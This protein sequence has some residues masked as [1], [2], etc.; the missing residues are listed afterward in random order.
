MAARCL[1]EFAKS[2]VSPEMNIPLQSTSV[3]DS[4]TGIFVLQRQYIL[5]LFTVSNL[6][7]GIALFVIL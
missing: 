5:L 6:K 1:T 4:R 3:D 7:L 2:T